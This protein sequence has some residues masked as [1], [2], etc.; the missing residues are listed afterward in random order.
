M[1][2]FFRLLLTGFFFMFVF[3]SMYSLY[4]IFVHSTCSKKDICYK[5]ILNSR[6][7]LDLHIFVS[8]NSASKRTDGV[9]HLVNF[10]YHEEFEKEIELEIYK[11]VRSN[12]SLF[13]HTVI[14][15][16]KAYDSKDYGLRELLNNEKTTYVKSRLTT[17]SVPV[18]ATFNL[19]KE[20]GTKTSAKP[21]PHLRSKYSIL[22]CT[23]ELKLP[24]SNLPPE[25][26]NHLRVTR[27][28]EFLPIAHQ[29]VLNMRLKDLVEITPKTKAVNF[30][31]VYKPASLGK[32]RFL[33]HIEATLYHFLKLGFTKKDLDEVKGVFVDTNLYL[34]CATFLI[35]SIHLLLDFLSFK[36]DV[37]FWKTQ[38]SMAGLSSRTVL[39]RAFSQTIVFLYLLDEGTSLLV[40]IPSGV[41]TLIE[42]C[43]F[44]QMNLE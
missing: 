14:I 30:T 26:L 35:G 25:I 28:K 38:T 22:M 11:S 6:P 36:N 37:S 10:D 27:N 19:L 5:S 2:P 39:W 29:D 21:V 9:L 8:D 1:N 32:L 44:F 33:L 24:H 41:A 16:S 23:E 17:Y 18:S 40:L 3:N 43:I 31:Y 20:Q 4:G 15:P 13:I 7:S 34:L 12:G 42:V